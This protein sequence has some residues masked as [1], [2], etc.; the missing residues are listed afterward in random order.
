MKTGT[1]DPRSKAMTLVSL[2]GLVSGLFATSPGHARE[3]KLIYSCA[4]LKSELPIGEAGRFTHIVVHAY[5][6]ASGKTQEDRDELLRRR[7]V[8]T[9]GWE[10]YYSTDVAD[11][12]NQDDLTR[13]IHQADELENRA[14][15]DCAA[16]ARSLNNM[17]R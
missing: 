8:A 13:M 11:D 6:T 17:S 10:R 2:L 7:F 3:V 14:R 15:R 9:G 5:V 12:A 16:V 4:I 1:S